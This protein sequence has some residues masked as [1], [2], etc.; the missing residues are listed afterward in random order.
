MRVKGNRGWLIDAVV[1]AAILAAVTV[2]GLGSDVAYLVPFLALLLP[3]LRGRYVGE[4]LIERWRAARQ[5]LRTGR[6]TATPTRLRTLVLVHRTGRSLA[7]ALAM[8][9]PPVALPITR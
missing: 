7:V 9:P 8:R 2:S 1:A 4:D 6:V 5:Q 3:M